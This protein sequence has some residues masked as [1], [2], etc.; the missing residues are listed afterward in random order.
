MNYMVRSRSRAVAPGRTR[1]RCA[2]WPRNIGEG[3]RFSDSR[4][5]AQT[6]SQLSYPLG[7][8]IA[9]RRDYLSRAGYLDERYFLYYE[10]ADWALAGGPFQLR[11]TATTVMPTHANSDAQ[12]KL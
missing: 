1:P 10:E 7:A 6:E 5:A 8:A 3:A 11:A 12:A 9:F 4:D 2:G